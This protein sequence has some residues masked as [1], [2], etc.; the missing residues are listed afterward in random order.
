MRDS[1]QKSDLA[2]K[3][4]TYKGTELIKKAME[5]IVVGRLLRKKYIYKKAQKEKEFLINFFK[6]QHNKRGRSLASYLE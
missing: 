1:A 2:D 3:M 5:K 6:E 4:R